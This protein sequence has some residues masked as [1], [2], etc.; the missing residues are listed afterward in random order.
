MDLLGTSIDV[1][2]GPAPEGAGPRRIR[3]RGC[4]N[5]WLAASAFTS[6]LP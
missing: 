5:Y 3:E 6:P 4:V 2:R 1:R